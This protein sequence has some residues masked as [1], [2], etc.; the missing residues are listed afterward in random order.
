M[1][2]QHRSTRRRAYSARRH[3]SQQL[4]IEPE[5]RS[6][7]LQVVRSNGTRAGG[8][9][10]FPTNAGLR[11]GPA[12]CGYDPMREI[13]GHPGGDVTFLDGHGMDRCPS[14]ETFR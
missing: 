12:L 8:A 5:P 10:R 14:C 7:W 6:A 3:E 13:A 1:T 4:A 9:H 2:E 11:D